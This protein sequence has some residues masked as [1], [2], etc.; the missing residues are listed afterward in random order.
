MTD[1]LK[2]LF[3]NYTTSGFFPFKYLLWGSDSESAWL[4]LLLQ[5][6]LGDVVPMSVEMKL[7][8]NSTARVPFPDY[9]CDSFT[10]NSLMSPYCHQGS[11]QNAQYNS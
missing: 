4:W 1:V 9:R 3:T 6:V 7:F 2:S 11:C 10:K 8:V 5:G